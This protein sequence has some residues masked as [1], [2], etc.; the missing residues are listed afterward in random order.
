MPAR[1]PHA[2]W[3][4]FGVSTVQLAWPSGGLATPR[5]QLARGS[6]V[7]SMLASTAQHVLCQGAERT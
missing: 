5:M 6:L 4:S 2:G 1:L 3:M 7:F